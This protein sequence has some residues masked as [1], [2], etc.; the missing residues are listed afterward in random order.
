[1]SRKIASGRTIMELTRKVVVLLAVLGG[2][3][4]TSNPPMPTEK[5]PLGKCLVA[6]NTGNFGNFRA[7]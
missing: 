5:F 3:A 1:M 7:T 6:N 2:T 4:A